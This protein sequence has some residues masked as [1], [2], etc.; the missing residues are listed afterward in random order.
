MNTPADIDRLADLNADLADAF[1]PGRVRAQGWLQ[2]SGRALVADAVSDGQPVVVK[3]FLGP[4]RSETIQRLQTEHD[5]IGPHMAA[6]P[7]RLAV[8]RNL[9][10]HH[11]LAVLHKA[12]GQRMD[13][14]LART[15]AAERRVILGLVGGWLAAFA[16]PRRHLA[17]INLHAL[18]RARKQAMALALTPADGD[19]AGASL[20]RLRGLAR[21]LTGMDLVQSGIH[22]DLTPDNLTLAATRSGV[23]VWA[24]DLQDT[25][26]RPVALDAAHF[27]VIAGLRLPPLPAP[28]T[29]GLPQA[30][31]AALVAACPD[32]D[33]PVLEFFIGDRLLRAL[34]EASTA[35]RAAAARSALQAWLA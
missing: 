20:S 32:A 15:K 24:F 25:R 17:P 28:L 9:S 27:L 35:D 16:A 34:H 7:Y 12:P 19:L 13:S 22:A 26:M 5:A 4:T 18:I 21:D 2:I 11:G 23:E 29:G 8:W 3:Q 31:R 6:G 30:D 10:P 14:V 33:G 1:G